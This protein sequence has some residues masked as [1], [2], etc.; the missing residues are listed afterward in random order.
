MKRRT[1]PAR[2]CGALVAAL[3]VQAAS[4]VAAAET[5]GAR[6]THQLT[7]PEYCTS[8]KGK[9]CTWVLME[10][11]GNAGKETAPRNGTVDK[12]RLVACA[13][14]GSFV[15]QVVRVKPGTEKVKAISTGPVVNYQ[16]TKR[17][18]TASKNFDVEEFDVD[19][20]IRKGQS[21]AVVATEVR[22]MYNSGSGPSIMY[23][24]PL[25]EGDAFRTTSLDSGFLMIQAEL[26]P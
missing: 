6:L 4:P 20:P 5:F 13:P 23:D 1:I 11:Q 18:C 15:L 10:A 8:N 9:M 19:V 17:N 3:A 2:M 25:A 26:A 12:I 22:F 24:P 21:L 7:P 14:A 16:G